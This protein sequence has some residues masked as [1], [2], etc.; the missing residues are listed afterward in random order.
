MCSS[1]TLMLQVGVLRFPQGRPEEDHAL[2]WKNVGCRL[3]LLQALLPALS[4]SFG[5]MTTS[6]LYFFLS[7]F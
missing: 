7:T 2:P 4:V 1:W 3:S 5:H 6:H